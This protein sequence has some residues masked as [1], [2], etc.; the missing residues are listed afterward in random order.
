[1]TYTFTFESRSQHHAKRA[2]KPLGTIALLS[3]ITCQEFE[4]FM[5]GSFKLTLPP[6]FFLYSMVKYSR[7]RESEKDRFIALL[8]RIFSNR[9]KYII[10]EYKYQTKL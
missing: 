2:L 3:S 10:E 6:P 8:G 5:S 7:G 9:K 4:T 1:M